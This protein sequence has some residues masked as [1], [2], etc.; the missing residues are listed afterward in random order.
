MGE[1]TTRLVLVL[2]ILWVPFS[3]CAAVIPEKPTDGKM[4]ND[5]LNE[6]M[7]Y[8]KQHHPDASA[9]IKDSM[10]WTEV[11]KVKKVGYTRYVYTSNGWKVTIGHPATAEVIYEVAAEHG[12]PAITWTGTIR[13]RQITETGYSVR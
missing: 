6:V 7:R 13:D 12:T 5:L 10:T 2:C 8:I 4:P 11:D 9:L 3:A 1:R